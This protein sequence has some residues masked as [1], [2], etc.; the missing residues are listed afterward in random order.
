MNP[1]FIPQFAGKVITAVL[2]NGNTPVKFKQQ[3]DELFIY[4]FKRNSI[5]WYRYN[6]S[7][8]LK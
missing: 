7:I 8:K 2:F 5:K 1:L 3:K 6:Y 4:L